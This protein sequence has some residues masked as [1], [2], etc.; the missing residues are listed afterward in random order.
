MRRLRNPDDFSIVPVNNAKNVITPYKKTVSIPPLCILATLATV[1]ALLFGL[2]GFIKDNPVVTEEQSTAIILEGEAPQLQENPEAVWGDLSFPIH[3]K[4]FQRYT[5]GFGYRVHPT[6]GL[7]AFHY[8]L[9]LA[10]PM[11][12]PIVAWASG[13]VSVSNYQGDCGETIIIKS[14]E[15]ESIYCHGQK[16]SRLV[17]EGDTVKAGQLVMLVGSTGAS[18]GP[19]LHW[20]LRYQGKWV[21]PNVVLVKMKEQQK[22]NP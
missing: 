4:Y 15:W 14:N 6:K 10:A 3:A 11:G 18:S 13:T 8:G 21:D 1:S 12:S 5:S 19:H 2:Q 20:G 16:N 9:D 22:A 17:R 7:G